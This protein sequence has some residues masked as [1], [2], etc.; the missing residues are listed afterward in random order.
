LSFLGNLFGKKQSSTPSDHEPSET[1]RSITVWAKDE[2]TARR[3]ATDEYFLAGI[4]LEDKKVAFLDAL[5]KA[6][7]YS[8][9]VSRNRSR[10]G[11]D[12]K[13][14]LREASFASARA[15][16]VLEEPGAWNAEAEAWD[17]VAKQEWWRAAGLGQA[18]YEALV[19][20]FFDDSL[21]TEDKN[22]VIAALGEIHKARAIASPTEGKGNEVVRPSAVEMSLIMALGQIGLDRSKLLSDQDLHKAVANYLEHVRLSSKKR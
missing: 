5:S 7:G 9:A 20:A 18:A 13:I 2:T 21:K 3:L 1:M 19:T 17:A 8:Y 6:G 15:A 22:K 12:V 14:T 16:Q 10:G 4:L 11:Y